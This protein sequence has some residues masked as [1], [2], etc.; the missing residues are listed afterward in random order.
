MQSRSSLVLLSLLLLASTPASAEPITF[1][2]NGT[3]DF[4]GGDRWALGDPVSGLYTF[5]SN[6]ARVIPTDG[7]GKSY[8]AITAFVVGIGGDTI[9]GSSGRIVVHKGIPSLGGESGYDVKM[10]HGT[11]GSSWWD[12]YL[13]IF[14]AGGFAPLVSDESIQTAPPSLVKAT[15][16]GGSILGHGKEYGFSLDRFEPVSVPEPETGWLLGAALAVV[17]V[18]H[19]T[20]R[21]VS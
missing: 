1:A 16:A 3:I 2:F 4:A 20:R 14:T 17:V 18:V 11:T 10:S 5:D 7:I 19:R 12:V 8:D 9:T 21:V 6:A 15:F 13:S